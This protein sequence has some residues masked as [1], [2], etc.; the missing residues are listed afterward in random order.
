MGK[1]EVRGIQR[2]TLE[3]RDVAYFGHFNMD[4]LMRMENLQELELITQQGQQYNRVTD[5]VAG[6]TR[7]FDEA[8]RSNP[9]WECPRIRILESDTGR[10]LTV[11]AGG[12]L[13]PGWKYG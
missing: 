12:A 13:L 8:R 7:D 6:L 1:D 4:V 3:V 9:G 11:I 2:M 10:K 5:L